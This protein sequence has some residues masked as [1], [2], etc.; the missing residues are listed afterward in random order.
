[1]VRPTS[2]PLTSSYIVEVE[3]LATQLQ[4]T[5]AVSSRG[6]GATICSEQGDMTAQHI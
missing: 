1:M 4:T 3:V 5:L 2:L 6:R